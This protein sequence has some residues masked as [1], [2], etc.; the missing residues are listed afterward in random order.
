MS[1]PGLPGP[2]NGRDPEIRNP[3]IVLSTP[4]AHKKM[5]LHNKS[6]KSVY[7]VRHFI[8]IIKS[9]FLETTEPILIK[10]KCWLSA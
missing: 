4:M 1:V 3:G 9:L 2:D 6:F 5:I 7:A 10:K 8:Q